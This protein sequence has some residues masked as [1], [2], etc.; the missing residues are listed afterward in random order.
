ML[1]QA[2][3]RFLCEGEF[4][5]VV[6]ETCTFRETAD[7]QNDRS[8]PLRIDI[9]MEVGALFDSHFQHKNKVLLFGIAIV[10]PC[11]SSTVANAVRHAG[12]HL[13]D[14]IEQKKYKYRDSFPATHSLLP[15]AISTYD[16]TG[17]DVHDLI[18]ELATR[19][20]EQRSEIHSN[21]FQHLAEGTEVARLRWR[22][23]FVLQQELSLRTRHHLR[24]QGWR[25]RVPNSS[26]RKAR[27]LYTRIVPRG[28]LDPRDENGVGVG[29]GDENGVGVGN[30]H[31][32]GD[33]DGD[34]DGEGTGR[35]WRREDD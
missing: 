23:S 13:A 9:A 16:G 24:R 31:G 11:A 2:L 4:Q 20:V 34:G 22:S 1:H 28:L 21:E 25:L 17:S 8:N 6:E 27:C 15:L 32:K 26:V 3:P 29:N 7:G 30:G 19:R 12:K 10:S 18:K 5:F 14:A 35:G 33:G